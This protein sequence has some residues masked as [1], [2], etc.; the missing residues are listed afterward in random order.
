LTPKGA[1]AV[2][3]GTLTASADAPITGYITIKDSD[4]TVRKLAVIT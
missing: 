2:R 4:G 1:G 3:F